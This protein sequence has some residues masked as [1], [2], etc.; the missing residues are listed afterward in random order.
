MK[1]IE[2]YIEQEHL[3][4][5]IQGEIYFAEKEYRLDTSFKDTSKSNKILL[6]IKADKKFEEKDV[7]LLKGPLLI[8]DEN[9]NLIKKINI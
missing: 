6:S 3:E 1:E 8:K 9:A 2:D 5:L 7:M 4:K